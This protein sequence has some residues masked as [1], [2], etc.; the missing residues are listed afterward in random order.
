MSNKEENIDLAI[1]A[2]FLAALNKEPVF[3]VP[4]QYFE[5]LKDQITSQIELEEIGKKNNAFETPKE[6]FE[7]SAANLLA[8]ITIEEKIENTTSNQNGFTIPENYF[9]ISKSNIENSLGL[10]KQKTAKIINLSFIRIAAAACILITCTIGIYLNI[11]RTN[12]I[13]YQ[14]S[15][16]SDEEIE[17]YLSQNTDISDVSLIVENLDPKAAFSLDNTQ[18]SKDEINIYLESTY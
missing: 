9:S 15:K 12:N 16:I 6:Y 13:H 3:F 17:T 1:E 14:L 5:T 10:K 8:R 18:I 2:P 7:N 4:N 11:N